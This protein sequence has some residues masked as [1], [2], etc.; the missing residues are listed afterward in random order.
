MVLLIK[1]ELFNTYDV[2]KIN[3]SHLSIWV[4][5]TPR[6]AGQRAVNVGV[7]YRQ[8]SGT[9]EAADL[10]AIHDDCKQ[11][12][13]RPG[14]AVA[15]GDINLD[16]SRKDDSNYARR[17]ML[18]GHLHA[19]EEAGYTL[20]GPV[21]P[22]YTSHGSYGD[23][24]RRTAVLDHAYVA[25]TNAVVEVL[26]DST[27]DHRPVVTSVDVG[28][29]PPPKT[30]TITRRN[31][32]KLSPAAF[33]A[34]LEALDW[35]PVYASTDVDKILDGINACIVDVLDRL[36]P[37][38]TIKVRRDRRLYLA[39]DTIEAIK[40]RDKAATNMGGNYRHLRNKASKLVRRDRLRSSV[41]AI[42]TNPNAAWAIAKSAVG[43]GDSGSL[44][45]RIRDGN[46]GHATEDSH[47]A[48]VINNFYHDKVEKI[49]AR[50]GVADGNG[51]GDGDSG[52]VAH[53][54]F[55]FDLPTAD[56]VYKVITGLRPT[57]ATADDGISVPVLKLGA[58][59]LAEPFAHLC[60]T[61]F[62]AAKVPTLYKTAAVTPVYKGGTKDIED[63]ASYRP[64]SILP[65][66]SKVLEKV[67]MASLMPYLDAHVLPD[68]QYGFRA[69]RS[70]VEAVAAATT[71]WAASTS[72]GR[73]VGALLFDYSSAFDTIS[74]EALLAKLAAYVSPLSLSWLSDYMS[75]G[76]QY[77]RWNGETS[78]CVDMPHGVRQGSILGPA[79]F[80]SL[81][82]DL[83]HVLGVSDATAAAYADDLV[84]WQDGDTVE[85]VSARL[86]AK[87]SALVKYAKENC[88]AL[89][90]AKTELLWSSPGVAAGVTVG[91]VAVAPATKPV[92]FLGVKIGPGLTIAPH[93]SHAA[94]K[95]ARAAHMVK[96]LAV[97]IPPGRFLRAVSGAIVN[98]SVGYA[99]AL[100]PARLAADAPINQS[101]RTIQVA[102]NDAARNACGVK[103]VDRVNTETILKRSGL[104]SVNHVAVR[105]LVTEAWKAHSH[106]NHR[107]NYSAIRRDVAAHRAVARP[108][109]ST[110][111]NL[112]PQPPRSTSRASATRRP[113]SGTAT[114]PS[115]RRSPWARPKR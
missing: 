36:T 5:L 58:R 73:I 91:D 53:G 74:R 83:P 65:A 84:V 49:R 29:R 57:T 56:T 12:A 97:S 107:N 79:L 4:S 93:F 25:G 90:E 9:S 47:K 99:M 63:P 44:P 104:C 98:G 20:A 94:T 22:T 28:T 76:T 16:V 7:I 89:N 24:G 71:A 38:K 102:I 42:A 6:S 87:A 106:H 55:A 3:D 100:A 62:T 103:R 48:T 113:T 27:T 69:G 60:R 34:A 95:A 52:I 59:A 35:S 11:A 50:I 39:P 41:T 13:A 8:W 2:A 23:G 101:M 92:S 54:S 45:A 61:S 33:T 51:G 72:Q 80:I 112:V 105:S 32:K 21:N 115:G 30:V 108:S 109:R 17:S 40:R 1:K 111:A 77:V 10:A 37:A 70:T 68:T 64:V 110:T 18:A 86:E 88:L 31:V 82:S 19:M 14:I 67:A 15:M 75:G 26:A 78:G 43:D 81:I 96:R 46:G 85:E 66:S 114:P